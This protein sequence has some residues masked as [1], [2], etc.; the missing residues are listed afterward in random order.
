MNQDFY[1]SEQAYRRVLAKGVRF[2]PL[3]EVNGVT[4]A[5][6]Q[7]VNIYTREAGAIEA[8]AV[9]T[10]YGSAAVDDL[11]DELEERGI[12]VFAAGDCVAP[13]DM[14]G[15]IVDALGVMQKLNQVVRS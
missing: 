12:T 6:V 11:V 2:Q 10:S 7:T 15:A 4:E 14:S 13:R 1:T 5:G 9:I 3:T 8:E